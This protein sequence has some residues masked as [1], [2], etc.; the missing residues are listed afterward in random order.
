MPLSEERRAELEDIIGD[1]SWCNDNECSC[2][3]AARQAQ[4]E[5]DEEMPLETAMF[6]DL[7]WSLSAMEEHNDD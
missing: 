5:L 1:A 3:E 7:G 2:H 4:E 6:E